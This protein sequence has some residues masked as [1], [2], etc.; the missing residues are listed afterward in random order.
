MWIQDCRFEAP[1]VPPG[2]YGVKDN[3]IWPTEARQR[4]SSYKGRCVVRAG[5]SIDDVPQPVLEKSL[6]NLPFHS[7][8]VYFP[9]DNSFP[10]QT[11]TMG[12]VIDSDQSL[13]M[14]LQ[15]PYLHILRG[16]VC[17]LT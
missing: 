11:Q 9:V 5:Y 10:V 1:A 13:E 6:G 17:F 12:L 4:G 15:R 16:L 7:H 2:T 8:W 14:Q 3:R